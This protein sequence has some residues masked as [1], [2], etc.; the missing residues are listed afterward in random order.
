LPAL[1][2]IY[3][4]EIITKWQKEGVAGIPPSKNQQLLTLLFADNEVIISNTEDNL[5]KAVHKL[6]TVITEHGLN[7]SV[8]KTKSMAL[9]GPEQ[10][11]GNIVIA[12]KIIEQVHSFNYLQNLISYEKSG[13]C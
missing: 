8:Q 5:Q 11:S 2:N 10:V 7:I 3:L 6:N 12:N 1:F 13:H 4:D 9:K